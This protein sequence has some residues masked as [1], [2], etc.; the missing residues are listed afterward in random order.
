M[1]TLPQ[2]C[3]PSPPSLVEPVL[4]GDRPF[5]YV[6]GVTVIAGPESGYLLNTTAAKRASG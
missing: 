1:A 2:D 5:R 6:R 3:R 4:R